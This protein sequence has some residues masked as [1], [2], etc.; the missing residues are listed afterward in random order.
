MILNKREDQ[1]ARTRQTRKQVGKSANKLGDKLESPHD[2]CKIQ[3]CR[4][5]TGV[6]IFVT[7]EWASG[8]RTR[9]DTSGKSIKYKAIF[10]YSCHRIQKRKRE[11]VLDSRLDLLV[12]RQS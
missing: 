1:P 12:R 8:R 2:Q 5:V 6:T 11:R 7:L 3:I 10:L 9:E 4:I